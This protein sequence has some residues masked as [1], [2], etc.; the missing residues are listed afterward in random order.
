MVFPRWSEIPI[1]RLSSLDFH[2][3]KVRERILARVAAR[4]DFRTSDDH[5]LTRAVLNVNTDRL[6]TRVAVFGWPLA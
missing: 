1:S 4:K 2:P 3:A 6:L 5:L